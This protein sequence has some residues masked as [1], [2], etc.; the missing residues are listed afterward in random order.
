M[1]TARK[2]AAKAVSKRNGRMSYYRAYDA[3][4]TYSLDRNTWG[5]PQ[6]QSVQKDLPECDRLQL[7]KLNRYLSRN[8][9]LCAGINSNFITYAI[10]PGLTPVHVRAEYVAY[11]RRW[12]KAPTVDGQLNYG[13]VQR[14]LARMVLEDGEGFTVK[15]EENGQ[16][17]LQ[18]IESQTFGGDADGFLDGV[19]T[20]DFGRPQAYRF[21]ATGKTIQAGGVIHT[22]DRIRPNQLRGIPK[23]AHAINDLMDQKDILKFEKTAQKLSAAIAGVFKSQKKDGLSVRGSQVADSDG[24][25]ARFAQ[26]TGVQT[27]TLNPNESFE[28][29]SNNRAGTNFIGFLDYL[30]R[31]IAAGY[32]LPSEFVWNAIG[33]GGATTRLILSQAS[34][35]FLDFR[36]I[37]ASACD[38]HWIYVIGDGIAQ[39][40]LPASPDWMDVVWRGPVLPTVDAGRDAKAEIESLRAG[41]TSPQQIA[42]EN[43]EDWRKTYRENAEANKF[44]LE[45]ASEYGVPAASIASLS[46]N[47]MTASLAVSPD[48][49]DTPAVETAAVAGGSVAA[50]A[51]NGAQVS[52]L[53]EI[54]TKVSTGE[55]TA[56]QGKAIAAASFPFV[57]EATLNLI[58]KK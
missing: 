56:E 53:V 15:T 46:V 52:S 18:V 27:I 37:I 31:R 11:F 2:S 45:L 5:I 17:L 23:G 44:V 36:R 9:G 32:K 38:A 7:V 35:A 13:D 43:N 41:L 29:P 1:K 12:S 51:L 34:S 14:I 19:K 20:N 58:F 25:V 55:L 4:N 26:M 10:G 3:A 8:E 6:A 40:L 24:N 21:A 30:T 48:T 33:T 22:F 50:T 16:A 28:I 57:D 49:Q 42:D 54:A 39:G 47:D